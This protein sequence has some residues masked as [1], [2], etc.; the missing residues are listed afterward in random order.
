MMQVVMTIGGPDTGDKDHRRPRQDS[1]QQRKRHAARRT[2]AY[3]LTEGVDGRDEAGR[4]QRT[5]QEIG[6]IVGKRPGG[7]LHVPCQVENWRDDP[8]D[9]QQEGGDSA[10]FL[11]CH[12]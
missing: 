8:G 11:Q 3:T 10:P 9:C 1:R 2:P 5:V 7:V 4:P 6:Q 12:G